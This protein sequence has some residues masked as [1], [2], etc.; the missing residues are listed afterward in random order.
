MKLDKLLK[1]KTFIIPTSLI[2]IFAYITVSAGIRLKSWP[3][4]LI[5]LLGII[6]LAALAFLW[7]KFKAIKIILVNL[8]VLMFFITAIEIFLGLTEKSKEDGVKLEKKGSYYDITRKYSIPYDETFGYRPLPG[9]NSEDI[10]IADGKKIREVTYTIAQDGWRIGPQEKSD[11]CILFFGGSMTF[12][13]GLNNDETFAWICGKKTGNRVN[14]FSFHG[15]GPHQMLSGI[16]SGEVAK[17]VGKLKAKYAIYTAIPYH[18]ERS[19]GLT[20]WDA[21]GPKYEIADDGKPHRNGKFMSKYAGYIFKGIYSSK[22]FI[23]LFN[24]YVPLKREHSV[25][26]AAAIVARSAELLEQKYPGIKFMVFYWGEDDDYCKAI[27]ANGIKVIMVEE[28]IKDYDKDPE[29]YKIPYDGHPNSLAA[30][31]VG[32]YLGQILKDSGSKPD[33]EKK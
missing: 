10:V 28:A 3:F 27:K 18:P 2:L 4:F 25:K 22:L 26:L 13:E 30:K 24:A 8:A 14:N 15:Y 19:A 20:M 7:R 29:K 31:L 32:N 1:S 5:F 33:K 21:Y 16:E 12:G 17:C 11:N 9:A 23:R 6:L